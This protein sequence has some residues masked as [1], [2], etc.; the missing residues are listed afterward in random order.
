MRAKDEL[1]FIDTDRSRI[2][3]VERISI[4]QEPEYHIHGKTRCLRCEHWCW[5]GNMTLKQVVEQKAT[6]VCL[7][8]ASVVIP[9]DDRRVQYGYVQDEKR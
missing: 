2:V 6:P 5:L 4:F 1:Q 7:E 8:C 9:M 3:V